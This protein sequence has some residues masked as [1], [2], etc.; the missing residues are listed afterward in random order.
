MKIIAGLYR[1]RIF[2]MPTGIRPT[3]DVHRKALFD[4]LQGIIEGAKFLDLFAG[5]GAVG[6]EALSRGA[7]EVVFAEKEE[8]CVEIIRENLERLAKTPLPKFRVL[9]LDAFSTIRLLHQKGE[10]FDLIFLDPPY[11][12]GEK[13]RPASRKEGFLSS[14][15][16]EVPLLAKK[17]LQTLASYDI[18]S[19]NGLVI[20]QHSRRE[21]LPESCAHLVLCKQKRDGDTVF[22]IF[23]RP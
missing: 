17:T 22:S 15:G 23:G 2:K 18:L 5:S 12:Q 3:Q 9:A 19:P 8:R 7:G 14:G 4:I 10:S 21:E 1:G 6:L 13:H 16:E 20:C 11:Y